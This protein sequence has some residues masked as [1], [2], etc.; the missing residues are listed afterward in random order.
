MP[1]AWEYPWFASW[2]LGY[3]AAALAVADPA[4]ARRQLLLLLGDRYLSPTGAIPAYEW[5]FS[6]VNPPVQGWAALEIAARMQP[7]PERNEF[8]QR[9]LHK[10]LLVFGWWVNRLDPDGQNLFQGGFLGLDN[11]GPFDRSHQPPGIGRL[12]QSDATAWTAMFCLDLAAIAIELATTDAAYED[13]AVSLVE[14]FAYVA[15]AM[16]TSG[17]WD[18]QDGFC[19]DVLRQPDGT[20]LPLRVRSVAGLVVLAAIRSVPA[21]ALTKLPR[22]RQRLARFLTQNAEY[23]ECV[24]PASAWHGGD[25]DGS[26]VLSVLPPGRMRRLLARVLDED[27][28]LSRYG[29]RS[30]SKWHAANPYQIPV[31][32]LPYAPVTYEPAE[33][34]SGMY[35]GNSNW[36]GPIWVPLN[37]LAITGLRRLGAAS[38][39]GFEVEYP[40]RSGQLL[41]PTQLA[42]DLGRRLSNLYRLNADGKLPAA[43]HRQW[44]ANLI[45]FHEYFHGD[46]GAGLGA[47]HQTG[48]TAGLIN[49][50][51]TR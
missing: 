3:Q 6:D 14:H 45:Q 50:L 10:L 47:A 24:Q 35:G 26:F 48:W 18:E 33:S 31:P 13:L 16:E 32:E 44:P 38:A 25:D 2:D 42:S 8:L 28:F 20:S 7:G 46:T 21:T 36:R 4:A 41:T 11:I 17:L 37:L 40:T 43:G 15:T 29:L 22:V 19:Y 9:V 23:A 12:D 34:R 39:N 30:L 49:L 51:T 27:E 5:S 1:D